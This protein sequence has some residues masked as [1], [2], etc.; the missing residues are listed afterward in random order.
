MILDAEE[1]DAWLD[2]FGKGGLL[3]PTNWYRGMTGKENVEEEK[4]DLDAGKLTTKLNVPVLA[5]DS[6]P[7]RAS[8]PGFLVGAMK[9]HAEQLTVKVV[10]SEGHYPH[11]VSKEE[12]NQAL[13]GLISAIDG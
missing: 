9:P 13:Y 6:K 10:E 7:D 1:R 5:I 11:I 4:A 3:G 2:A 8:L 12:V